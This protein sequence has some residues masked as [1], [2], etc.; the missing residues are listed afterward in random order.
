MR[1]IVT[2]LALGLALL[3]GA[4]ALAYETYLTTLTSTGTSVNYTPTVRGPWA[5]QCDAAAY[6]KVGKGVGTAATTNDVQV[7]PGALYDLW[8]GYIP[9]NPIDTVA[10]MSVSGTAN[11]RLY[12]VTVS[13]VVH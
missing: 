13:G 1:K 4:S 9:S 8:V 12:G 5:V 10:V 6:V 3:G 11:C 2:A 7:Q